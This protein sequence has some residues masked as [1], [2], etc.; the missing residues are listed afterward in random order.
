MADGQKVFR[1]TNRFNAFT[2]G[3]M[4]VSMTLL[5]LN[6]ELPDDIDRLDGAALLQALG[7]NWSNYLGYIIS[8][9][10]IA[11][12]WLGYT[13]Y[14]GAIQKVDNGFARL[15]VL[16]LLVVG[17]IPFVTA[18][19]SRNDG[20]V[21]TQLYAANMIAVSALLIA[22]SFYANRHGLLDRSADRD[23][24]QQDVAPWL[25]IIVVF[26]LSIVI[27]QFEAGLGKLFW[28]ALA[29]PHV[30]RRPKRTTA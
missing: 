9:L 24:W 10:V 3:V 16:F 8:F 28:L 11:Q 29:I 15:N 5:I 30:H 23:Q 19:I 7:T 12:Y 26:G 13:D 6:V 2:D 20:S 1:E 27:A 4:V 14:F 22:M 17:F 25:R 18:L 21:A